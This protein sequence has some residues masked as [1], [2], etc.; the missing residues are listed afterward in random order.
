[1]KV[2]LN[3][4]LVTPVVGMWH[5]GA[6]GLLFLEENPHEPENLWTAAPAWQELSKG[7]EMILAPSHVQGEKGDLEEEGEGIGIPRAA[8]H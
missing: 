5:P 2:L 3:P 7:S 1:M 6:G 4:S 8:G